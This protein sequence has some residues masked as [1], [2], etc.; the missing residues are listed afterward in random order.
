MDE[1]L[2][3]LNGEGMVSVALAPDDSLWATGPVGTARL[4]G[5]TWELVDG[6]PGQAVAIG[7]EGTAWVLGSD[8]TLVSW[9]PGAT[10]WIPERHA[11]NESLCMGGGAPYW[12]GV[13]PDRSVWVLQAGFVADWL[14]SYDGRA[15]TE[16]LGTD[17]AGRPVDQVDSAAIDADGQ[18]WVTWVDWRDLEREGSQPAVFGTARLDDAGWTVV[19]EGES[20][21][22]LAAG[23]DGSVWLG[24][25][26]G[27]LRYDG[28]GWIPDR[29]TGMSVNPMDVSPDGAVW[30]TDGASGLYRLP[31]DMTS[32]PSSDG[33]PS[34][35]PSSAP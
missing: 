11:A 18:L 15:W 20:R 6:A 17:V 22:R 10:G 31:A 35:S 25:E 19:S 30:V 7:P 3:P 1:G 28:T 13:R 27:L 16:P 12:M 21:G 8:C 33:T 29:L 2:P 34:A 26:D 9:R 14:L 24:S 4:V 32:G 23:P 5:E